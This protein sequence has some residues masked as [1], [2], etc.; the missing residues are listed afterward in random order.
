[1]VQG[2]GRVSGILHS[3]YATCAY[4]IV[5]LYYSNIII[6]LYL[7][8]Q[9]IIINNNNIAVADPVATPS[10]PPLPASLL[11]YKLLYTDDQ[12]LSDIGAVVGCMCRKSLL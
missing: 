6:T 5:H 1:M 11:W 10:A 9:I 12:N 7:Y 2:N 3:I 8:I 4:Y